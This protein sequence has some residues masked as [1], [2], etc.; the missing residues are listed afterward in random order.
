MFMASSPTFAVPNFGAGAYFFTRNFYVGFSAPS[1][2]ENKITISGADYNAS[3]LFRAAAIHYY[4]H[5]GYRRRLTEKFELNTS[6]LIKQATAAPMQF[7]LNA[8]MVY[9]NRFG[10]GLSYRT[11]KEVL[12]L[13]NVDIIPP[14]KFGYAY[15]FNFGM[16][17]RA[18]AGSHEVM[19]IY[20]FNPPA[21]PIVA[22][23]RF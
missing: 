10:F 11:S 22:V 4:A 3:T 9:N 12:A 15:E 16:I 14:L 19:L 6:V 18:S 7:D 17:G 23:P 13:F 21:K 2:L 8:Q 20:K 1:L 5:A